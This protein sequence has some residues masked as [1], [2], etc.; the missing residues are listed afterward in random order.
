MKI[1]G[2]TKVAWINLDWVRLRAALLLVMLFALFGVVFVEVGSIKYR[3]IESDAPALRVIALCYGIFV[4]YKIAIGREGFKKIDNLFLRVLVYTLY[5]TIIAGFIASVTLVFG[6]FIVGIFWGLSSGGSIIHIIDF[7]TPVLFISLFVLSGT[8]GVSL[9]VK[10]LFSVGGFVT[11]MT[12]VCIA[13]LLV[14]WIR[15][16]KGA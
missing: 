14:K 5:N 6:T 9:V 4:G 11:A 13:W 10:T 12:T 3:E 2:K 8:A 7:R 16:E 1:G 15:E